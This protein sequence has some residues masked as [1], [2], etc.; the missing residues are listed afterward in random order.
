MTGATLPKHGYERAAIE[1]LGL[2]SER[3]IQVGN[4]EVRF[5]PQHGAV[6]VYRWIAEGAFVSR[7]AT[8]TRR[9][10]WRPVRGDAARRSAIES[11][12]IAAGSK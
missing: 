9:G 10:H 1:A 7:G 6:A 2:S 8:V 5:L 11:A 12:M 3:E 4:Y